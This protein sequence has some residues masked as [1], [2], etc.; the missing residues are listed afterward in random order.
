MVMEAGKPKTC[1]K[2][3]RPSRESQFKSKGSLLTKFLLAPQRSVF[4]LLR[5]SAVWTRPSHI[6]EGSLLYQSLLRR[7]LVSSAN[8]LH[9]NI[10]NDV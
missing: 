10:F 5:P 2:G 6:T 3:W 7:T 4:S 9:R 1:R 8:Y